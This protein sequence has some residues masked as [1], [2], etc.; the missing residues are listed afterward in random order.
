M[1]AKR[2]FYFLGILVPFLLTACFRGADPAVKEV[3]NVTKAE[4]ENYI[5]T[6]IANN[7][8]I[9][10]DASD[11]ATDEDNYRRS[12]TRDASEFFDTPAQSFLYN[13]IRIDDEGFASG[14]YDVRGLDKVKLGIRTP[15]QTENFCCG[16]TSGCNI[17]D[18]IMLTDDMDWIRFFSILFHELGHSR[19]WHNAEHA[20]KA[21]EVHLGLMSY[22]YSKP[23]G[24]LFLVRIFDNLSKDPLLSNIPNEL[25]YVRGSLFAI[26]NLIKY[27]G[28]MHQ[29][30]HFV[31]NARHLMVETDLER[32]LNELDGTPAH[33]YFQL[34]N[35][36][37]DYTNFTGYLQRMLP[38]NEAME[39]TDYL[40]I[41]N[42]SRNRYNLGIYQEVS[43]RLYELC[44]DFLDNPRYTNP[45]FRTKV[46]NLI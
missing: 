40:R 6:G 29:A 39:L 2:I 1:N 7:S 14:G 8:R 10:H 18:Y 37:L 38:Y 28:N 4:E 35:E 31:A 30:M 33:M 22:V 45:Y 3:P 13:L 9:V 11:F 46:Q 32:K 27:N 43:L 15:K 26:T 21:N 36:L 19:T 23:V 44:E 24:S 34:W 12:P 20:A 5:L 16:V 41:L 17:N 42:Y 25:M